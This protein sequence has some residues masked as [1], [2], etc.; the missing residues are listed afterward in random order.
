LYYTGVYLLC[1]TNGIFFHRNHYLLKCVKFSFWS[2]VFITY[3]VYILYCTLL[4]YY[5]LIKHVWV[6]RYIIFGSYYLC[7][8][9]YY[10]I[11]RQV[12]C[13][14]YNRI[15]ISCMHTTFIMDSIIETS[16][17]YSHIILCIHSLL[18]LSPNNTL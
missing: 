8:F 2:F 6:G 3:N 18:S 9:G 12:Y 4:L 10:V 17:F 1:Q 16:I 13:W 7:I 11:R 14:V 15:G 5:Y